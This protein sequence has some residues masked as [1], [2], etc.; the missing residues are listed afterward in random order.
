MCDSIK[1]CSEGKGETR[2]LDGKGVLFTN[3]WPTK[4]ENILGI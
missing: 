3:L 2:L 4:K 1:L